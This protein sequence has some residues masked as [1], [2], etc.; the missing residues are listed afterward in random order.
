MNSRCQL[1]V[2]SLTTRARVSTNLKSAACQ[3]FATANFSMIP[4]SITSEPYVLPH[5]DNPDFADGTTA[6]EIEPAA[7]NSIEVRKIDNL[8]HL[9]GRYGN[10][11]AGNQCLVMRRSATQPNRIH[12]TIKQLDP[13]RVYSLRMVSFPVGALSRG[14]GNPVFDDVSK[15]NISIDGAD[16]VDE[17]CFDHL[18]RSIHTSEQMYFNY[19]VRRFRAN[20]QTAKLTISDWVNPNKRGGNV[21]RQTGMH[22]IE[23]RPYLDDTQP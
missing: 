4:G 16:R 13:G 15:I 12:Q 9:A 20:A 14:S 1:M 19:H 8:G 18:Y 21:G 10:H 5:T 17:K 7:G 6:W 2:Y 22:S 23:I 11:Q 3:R